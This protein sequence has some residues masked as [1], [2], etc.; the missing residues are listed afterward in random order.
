M[1]IPRERMVGAATGSSLVHEV[2]H[3][4]SALLGLVPSL[5]P[6]LRALGRGRGDPAWRLR[7]RGSLVG[8]QADR[9]R[10]DRAHGRGQPAPRLRL[11]RPARRPSPIPLGPGAAVVRPFDDV[12]PQHPWHSLVQHPEAGDRGV[13]HARGGCGDPAARAATP[14]SARCRRGEDPARDDGGTLEKINERLETYFA[15]NPRSCTFVRPSG[16]CSATETRR[17]ACHTAPSS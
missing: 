5:R 4:V 15:S 10:D 11:P 8:Q 1:R 17:K 13:P 2:G 7:E 3:Q 12:S 14:R 6:V 16:R 9:G